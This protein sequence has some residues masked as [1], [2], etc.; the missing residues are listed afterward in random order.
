MQP[1]YPTPTHGRRSAGRRVTAPPLVVRRS[2][3]DRVG[4]GVTALA[5]VAGLSIS[6]AGPAQ[7]SPA[8]VLATAQQQQQRPAGQIYVVDADVVAPAIVRDG[9]AASDGVQTLTN[10]G[11]N[12][13]WARLV[14]MDGAWP[15]TDENIT[16]L[17][18]W[19]RQENGPPDWWNRNNPLNNGYGSGGGAGLGSYDNLQDAAQYAAANLHRGYPGI[20]AALAASSSAD[21]TAAA[22]WAS[23]WATSHYANGAHWSTAPVKIVKAPASAW[24]G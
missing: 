16:V 17:L 4:V 19:M 2:I 13:D 9:M 12:A 22:I 18:R 21:V 11:T 7:A 6:P 3:I 15:T 5:L 8:Q 1:Q 24:G 23:P 10:N 14:L 20:S